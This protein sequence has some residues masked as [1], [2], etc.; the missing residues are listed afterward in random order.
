MS[1]QIYQDENTA[2]G[3][4]FGRKTKRDENRLVKQNAP[5]PSKR[6]ALANISNHN[7]GS[8]IQPSRAV[9]ERHKVRL[10]YT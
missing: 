3:L 2:A 10:V 1:I 8:R 4:T 6:V 5:K 9:K 7:H